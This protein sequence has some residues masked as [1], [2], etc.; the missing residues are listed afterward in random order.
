MMDGILSFFER[1]DFSRVLDLLKYNPESPMIF[2]SGTFFLLFIG[3]FT[4]YGL[5]R[6]VPPMENVVKCCHVAGL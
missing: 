2:S 1:L 6:H 3:F 5:L 4:I